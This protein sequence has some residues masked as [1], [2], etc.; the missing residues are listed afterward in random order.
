[1][2]VD[3]VLP[4]RCVDG[5]FAERRRSWELA[6]D[7]VSDAGHPAVAV[8]C[9]VVD[10]RGRIGGFN[11]PLEDESSNIRQPTVGRRLGA[12]DISLVSFMPP[13]IEER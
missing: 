5:G 4:I 10:D 3:H 12:G 6:A 8:V 1:M 11:S 7:L 13:F 9:R 2:A